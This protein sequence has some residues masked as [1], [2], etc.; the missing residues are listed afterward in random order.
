MDA[1][2]KLRSTLVARM[3]AIDERA[4]SRGD[5]EGR[6]EQERDVAAMQWRA[7]EPGKKDEE[8]AVYV[9]V[10]S[11]A[12]DQTAWPSPSQYQVGLVAELDNVVEASVVQ[13]SFPL[14]FPTVETGWNTLAFSFSPFSVLS[15]VVV[16][17]GTYTGEVLALELMVQMNQAL[18]AGQIPAPYRM[19]FATGFVRN[20]AG[21][22]PPGANQFRVAY[23]DNRSQF[24]FQLVDNAELVVSSPAFALHSR[25]TGDDIFAQL[26]FPAA[27]VATQGVP[28]GA[29]YYLV[30]TGGSVFATGASVDQRYAYSL[31]S[32][33]AADLS[34][35]CA[36]VL[37]I[38]QLN[39]NDLALLASASADFN[40]GACLGLVYTKQPAYMS[41]K[42]LE[43][44][45]T[46][47][48]I[49]KTYR[50][51]RGRIQALNVNVRRVSGALVDFRGADHCFTLRIVVKR[52]QPLKPIFTR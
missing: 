52:T 20:N 48:P 6:F 44:N 8:E 5:E 16:P 1:A 29:Y 49:K 51:G 22:L 9:Y 43:F 50:S 30:N 37:D 36:F 11:A 2:S 24:R 38:P 23:D 17:P 41:D 4:R 21:N 27:Q 28:A 15:T 13:A 19:D 34:G 3:N 39:D 7:D 42:T 32:T 33:A 26:G 14:T 47:Y 45:S 46:S 12:R 35:P 25:K 18:F 10:S 31:S 40:V